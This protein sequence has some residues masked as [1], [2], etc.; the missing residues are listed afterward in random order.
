ME[1]LEVD[2]N[3]QIDDVIDVREYWA[4]LKIPFPEWN[5]RYAVWGVVS[6]QAY[7]FYKVMKKYMPNAEL[8]AVIDAMAEGFYCGK[9][10]IKP[11]D[12]YNLPEDCIIILSD[13]AAKESARQMLMEL[14][15]PFVSLKGTDVEF[16]NF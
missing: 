15:R 8:M 9:D 1:Y 6:Q 5:F 14:E 2:W 3:I 4:M 13:L 7:N 10:I 16:Y 12:I 11:N